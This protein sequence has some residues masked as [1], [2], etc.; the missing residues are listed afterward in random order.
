MITPNGSGL[1]VC[2]VKPPFSPFTK[3][4]IFLHNEMEQM[5]LWIDLMSRKY[6]EPDSIDFVH[7]P[8]SDVA[9]FLGTETHKKN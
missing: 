6:W 7:N 1:I 8:K 5:S 3:K 9:L 2:S 4:A